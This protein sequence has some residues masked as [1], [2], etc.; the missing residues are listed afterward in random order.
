MLSG[1]E[2][3]NVLRKITREVNTIR[4]HYFMDYDNDS[5]PRYSSNIVI[6]EWDKDVNTN[7]DLKDP[8]MEKLIRW[9]LPFVKKV[10]IDKKDPLPAD[11]VVEDFFS[12]STR[13]K[14]HI[15]AGQTICF[16]SKDKKNGKPTSSEFH[17]LTLSRLKQQY[18][19]TQH[20]RFAIP[21]VNAS[22]KCDCSSKSGVCNTDEYR[23]GHC[24]SSSESNAACYRTLFTN[25]P[26]I[27]CSKRKS[28]PKLCCDVAFHPY[29]KKTY[30]ALKLRNPSTFAVFRYATFRW[31]SGRWIGGEKKKIT[32]RLD[33]SIANPYLDSSDSL[34][35]SIVSPG[36]NGN[37]LDPGMYFVENLEGDKYGELMQQPLN[38]ET[39]H[40]FDRLGWFRQNSEGEFFVKNG[41]IMMDKIH[42]AKVKNCEEQKY[43]SILDANFY[44]NKNS[45]ESTRFQM[46][47]NLNKIHKWIKS[48]RVL[49]Q[50][51]RHVI[52]TESKGTSL[53]IVLTNNLINEKL[54]FI[55]NTSIIKDFVG[56]II[57]DEYS[58]S[59]FN[60]TVVNA[61]GI[62][63]GYIRDIEDRDSA[64]IDPFT[65]YVPESNPSTKRLIL[66]IKSYPP[67][68]TKWVCLRPDDGP[69]SSEICKPVESKQEKLRIEDMEN[70]WTQGVGN[71]PT[72]NK[73][74]SS[75]FPWF[76]NPKN[77]FGEVDSMT[78]FF[79]IITGIIG[80]SC[81]LL[82]FCCI[83]SKLVF[84]LI[85]C[86]L[87]PGIS[88]S[89]GRKM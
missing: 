56:T 21:E 9:A 15:G 44:I 55:H 76:F 14:L 26:T 53:E 87:C 48:A 45:N 83:M 34:Q 79:I 19:I 67:N 3:L 86:F 31:S 1:K 63:N 60:L 59:F 38:E 22:C 7:I 13:Y 35:L 64:N 16:K 23:F 49:D 4:F 73:F 57:V 18:S 71:C 17:V 37:H 24:T 11:I 70:K 82:V 81:G 32:V 39:D 77:W 51:K 74:S 52:V 30:T 58:N 8:R 85:N 46:T 43:E 25:Q 27:G 6:L 61:S 80:Y 54:D 78:D 29:Q 75:E 50:E 36:K 41:Y 47:E 65:L 66:S 10:E 28:E 20:Y 2:P 42:R 72:C 69:A 84:P 40:N 89:R 5:R 12:E 33:G 68:I 88:Y 62:I